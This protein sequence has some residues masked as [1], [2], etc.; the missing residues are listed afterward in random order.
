MLMINIF[1]ICFQIKWILINCWL[2]L[3]RKIIF[4]TLLTFICYIKC[5]LN[6]FIICIKYSLQNFFF[7]QKY[8]LQ[9]YSLLQFFS[10]FI[11]KIFTKSCIILQIK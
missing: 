1:I 9:K 4:I 3:K 6:L 11:I 8:I 2:S 5:I 10:L 7:L